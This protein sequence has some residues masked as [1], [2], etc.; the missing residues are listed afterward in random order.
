ME[1]QSFIFAARHRVAL[2]IVDRAR[3]G[4]ESRTATALPKRV[5]CADQEGAT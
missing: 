5:V 1:A 4:Q 3:Q 2:Q